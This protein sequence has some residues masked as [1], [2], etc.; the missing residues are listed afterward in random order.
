MSN[1][2]FLEKHRVTEPTVGVP[3]QYVTNS[4]WGFCGMFRF[5][6][7]GV[8]LRCVISDGEGWKHVS[9]SIEGDKRPPKW[10]IM[11]QVKDLFWEPNDWVVQFHPAQSDY[12]NCHP[13]CLH[14]FQPLPPTP[15]LPTPKAI[16]V[17][18]GRKF[19]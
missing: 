14:L 1:W 10:G 11:C 18:P 19:A 9:V 16:L 12:V 13:G 5:R 2:P 3:P 4:T 15:P 7:D 6:L 17:G 8:P